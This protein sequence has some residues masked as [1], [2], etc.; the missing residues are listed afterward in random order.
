MPRPGRAIPI[1][2]MPTTGTTI[3]TATNTTITGR[4]TIITATR[5]MSTAT[6]MAKAGP[7]ICTPPF[8]PGTIAWRSATADS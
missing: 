4:S 1:T 6:R 7:S 2:T 8:W 5:I 3:I